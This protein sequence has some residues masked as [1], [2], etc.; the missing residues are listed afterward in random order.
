MTKVHEQVEQIETR[1]DLVALIQALRSEL[2]ASPDEWENVTLE[3][4]LDALASWTED[5]DAVL[6]R[7]GEPVPTAPTWRTFGQMLLAASVYE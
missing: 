5:M 3:R 4:F 2:A 7:T 6:S 1:H